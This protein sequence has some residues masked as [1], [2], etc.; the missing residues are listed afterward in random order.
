MENSP[1]VTPAKDYSLLRGG[2]AF[3]WL[4][5]RITASK[6]GAHSSAASDF[7]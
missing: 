2:D 1:I 6:A 4:R 5:T 7:P 3:G